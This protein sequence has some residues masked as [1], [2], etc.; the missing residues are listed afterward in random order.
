MFCFKRLFIYLS[1]CLGMIFILTVNSVSAAD[2]PEIFVQLGHTSSI[3]AVEFSP[4]GRFVLSGS[5]DDSI[6]LWEADNGRLI[7]TFKDRED[8]KLCCF[9]VGRFIFFR[10]RQRQ[11][12]HLGYPDRKADS[13]I[14]P[15]GITG[16]P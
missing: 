6:K 4:D 11:Y 10:Q 14:C 9:F 5:G 7:R 3:N 16:V 13:G 12:L 8:V 1:A 15:G 2:K